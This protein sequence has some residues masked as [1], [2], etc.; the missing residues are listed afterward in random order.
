MERKLVRV[1]ISFS[2]ILRPAP[3]IVG[4]FSL[5]V[6]A[7]EESLSRPVSLLLPKNKRLNPM[8]PPPIFFGL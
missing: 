4:L 2:S 8:R 5:G 7:A 6:Y 1:T 3:L